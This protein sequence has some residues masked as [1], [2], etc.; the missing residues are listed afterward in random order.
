MRATVREPAGGSPAAGGRLF[1]LCCGWLL[2]RA[3]REGEPA[4]EAARKQLGLPLLALLK[5]YGKRHRGLSMAHATDYD[6]IVEKEEKE[7]RGAGRRRISSDPP[8]ISS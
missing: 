5:G 3:A 6:L 7:K 8:R 1:H 2:R 4:E